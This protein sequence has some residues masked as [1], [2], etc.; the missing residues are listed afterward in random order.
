MSKSGNAYI[1]ATQGHQSTLY[2]ACR[3]MGIPLSEEQEKFQA[4][5]ER[6]YPA[7]V[8]NCV[9]CGSE[10]EVSLVPVDTPNNMQLV[11]IACYEG[12]LDACRDAA[13]EDE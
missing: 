4:Y 6:T 10:E 13:K 9:F 3:A 1:A 2:A 7:V 11:C 5:L 12:S 8:G